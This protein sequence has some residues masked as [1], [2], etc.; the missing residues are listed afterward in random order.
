MISALRK[1]SSTGKVIVTGQDAQKD[2]FQNIAEG[3]QTMTIYKP[4]IPLAN[5][6]VEAAIKLVK[7]ETLA[8]AKPFRNDTLGKDIPA[9]LLEIVVVDKYNL[10]TMVIKDGFQSMKMFTRMFRLISVRRNRRAN[11]RR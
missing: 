7:K 3:K 8:A 6:A 2:A 5:A 1:R 11:F 4:I 10:M 9:I